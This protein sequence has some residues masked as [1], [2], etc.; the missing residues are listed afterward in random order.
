[1]IRRLGLVL[2]ALTMFASAACAVVPGQKHALEPSRSGLPFET[3][4]FRS[5]ADSVGLSGWWFEG[6]A[7]SPVIVFCSR[8]TGTMAD[9]LPSVREMVRRGFTVFTFDYRDFGP[10]GPGETDSLRTL[11]FATRWVFDAQGAFAF[12]RSRAAGRHVFAWGQD[13]GGPV[14]LAVGARDARLV[15]AIAVEGLFRTAIEQVEFNG[16]AQIPGV[17][18]QHRLQVDTRDEPVATVPLLHVP[19]LAIIAMKD[20]VTPPEITKKLVTQSLSRIDR[21]VIPTAGHTGAEL[22]PGYFDRLAG[23]YKGLASQLPKPARL[24]P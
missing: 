21:W 14:A 16:T 24:A 6:P 7:N 13:L 10:G 12:A 3:V 11:V 9:L 20:V 5:A 17:L 8:G 4:A 19:L 1:V 23:W 15:D 2:A 18:P 22:T